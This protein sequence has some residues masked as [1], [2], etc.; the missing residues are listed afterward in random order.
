MTEL[1]DNKADM[2]SG[3]GSV[4][5]PLSEV[6]QSIRISGKIYSPC[7]LRA[8]WGI[9]A[10]GCSGHALFYMI[11]RGSALLSVAEHP[12]IALT[13][14]DLVLLPQATS[15]TLQDTAESPV[16]GIETLIDFE[17]PGPINFGGGGL[18]TSMVAGCFTYEFNANHPFIAALPPVMH[19]TA[20]D[21]ETE[22]WL[23][24]TFQFLIHEAGQ[25]KQGSS[26]AIARLTDLLFIQIMRVH[27]QRIKD[28][29]RTQG[30]LKAMTDPQIGEAISLMHKQPDA[31]WT[32]AAL[33]T[34]VGMSRSAFAQKFS[35]YTQTT[36]VDYLTFWRM[37][38]AKETLNATNKGLA[39][40]SQSV[41]YQSE[42][43]FSK[44]FRRV[45]G[46]SPGVFRHGKSKVYL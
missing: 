40:I 12:P 18:K 16:V 43:A 22:P 32:V 9:S 24:S 44:A 25:P 45:V 10:S 7:Q 33:A 14:G 42:A 3:N 39:E 37:E 15:H 19:L 28:C 21:I 2:H 31:P 30:W 35:Q 20:E 4:N 46:I 29:P 36:P 38:K 26:L 11:S 23:N 6:F 17:N 1:S 5:D 27:M 41:G 34:Q 13:G 8:P